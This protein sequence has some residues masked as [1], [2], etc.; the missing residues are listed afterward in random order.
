MRELCPACPP[1]A[2]RSTSTVRSPSDAPYTALPSPA[3][4]PPITI[5]S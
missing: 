4:P 3:G 1:V 2:C 5:R